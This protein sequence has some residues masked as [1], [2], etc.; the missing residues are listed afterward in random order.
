MNT[1]TCHARPRPRY[2]CDSGHRP[3]GGWRLCGDG[4]W[5]RVYARSGA[6][7][8]RRATVLRREGLWFWEVE[9]FDAWR[10]TRRIIARCG[11]GF[12]SLFAED[13]FRFADLAA[14]SKE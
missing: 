14:E 11:S 1:L 4:R 6:R 8:A 12:G 10:R 7:L 13:Q 3:L 2:R 5:R 9:A